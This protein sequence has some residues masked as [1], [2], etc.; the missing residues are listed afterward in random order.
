MDVG[1]RYAL[2]VHTHGTSTGV[3]SVVIC[4]PK[5]T[6]KRHGKQEASEMTLPEWSER[7]YWIRLII[8]LSLMEHGIIPFD[9]VRCREILNAT[10]PE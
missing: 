10:G 2:I 3:T 8:E 6:R 7:V 1:A 9:E 5:P 4:L